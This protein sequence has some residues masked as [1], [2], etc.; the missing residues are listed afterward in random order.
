MTGSVKLRAVVVVAVVTVI[1]AD[2]TRIG[3]RM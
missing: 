3:M 1:A 2:V